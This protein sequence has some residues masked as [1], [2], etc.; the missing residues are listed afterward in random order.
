MK[1][2]VKVPATS[3]NVGAGFDSLGLAVSMYNTVTF[4]ESDRLEISSCDGTIVP[5]GQSNLVYRA[6]KAV[7]DQLDEKLPGLKKLDTQLLSYIVARVILEASTIFSSG[8]HWEVAALCLVNAIVVALA[9]NGTY[10]ILGNRNPA[11]KEE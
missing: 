5:T 3:A 1:I 2:F 7:F 8:F 9:S 10:D 4:E 6:V 11:E